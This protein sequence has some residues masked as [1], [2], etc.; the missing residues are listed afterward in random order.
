[1]NEYRKRPRRSAEG[2]YARGDETRQRIVE[3]AM[4]LFGEYG[5]DGASTRDIAAAAGV[6]APALQYY[7]GNKQGVYLACCEGGFRSRALRDAQLVLSR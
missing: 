1:M 2:G 7:F 6:N 4:N 3:A 5:F